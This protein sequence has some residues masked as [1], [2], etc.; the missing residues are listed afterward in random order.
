MFPRFRFAFVLAL[1]GAAPLPFTHAAAQDKKSDK[2]AEPITK[3]QRVFTC[4]HSFHGFVPG[5][6]ADLASKAD[7]KDHVQ[8]GHSSIGGSQIKRHWD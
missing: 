2:L 6:L 5:I 7:I 4:S 3:G 1:L 8:V